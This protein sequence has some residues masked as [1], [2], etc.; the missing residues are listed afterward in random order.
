MRRMYSE[1]ELT[2]IIGEV[3]DAKIEAGAFDESISDAVDAYLVEHPVDITALEGKTI[4]PA[5]VN[6]TTSVGAP[7]GAFTALSGGAITGDS[8]IEN[9]SGYTAYLP[10]TDAKRAVD[11]IYAGACKNGNKLTLVVF[12]SF[13]V[14]DASI[15]PAEAYIWTEF[16]IP[17]EVMAKLFPFEVGGGYYL[18]IK[19][20]ECVNKSTFAKVNVNV[21]V[22][23]QVSTN[24]VAFGLSCH[25][26]SANNTYYF[27][28]EE[29]FLLSDNLAG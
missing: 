2:K 27:R 29:T 10:S 9:M 6:A 7:S 11:I 14:L 25:G 1:Q 13:E 8:I 20:V 12:G 15:T 4:A 21:D 16:G 23:K 22:V 19:S 3:F 26:Q 5:V 24:R 28:I 17:P 18:D